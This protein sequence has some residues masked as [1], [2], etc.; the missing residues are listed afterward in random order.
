MSEY[1]NGALP[2]IEIKQG[3]SIRGLFINFCSLTLCKGAIIY[4][5]NTGLCNL[6]DKTSNLDGSKNSKKIVL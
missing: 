3:D 1:H 5:L 6:K 4:L 2:I